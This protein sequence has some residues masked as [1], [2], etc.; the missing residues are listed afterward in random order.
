M[1][2]IDVFIIHNLSKPSRGLKIDKRTKL[3]WTKET[4]RDR[5]R[6]GESKGMKCE[7]A[8]KSNIQNS[9]LKEQSYN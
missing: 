5:E 6:D 3:I 2:L 9:K 8:R 1:I 7:W 4:E